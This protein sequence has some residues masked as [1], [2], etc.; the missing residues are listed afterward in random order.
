MRHALSK[1]YSRG[2]LPFKA[3]STN[4]L[5]VRINVTDDGTPEEL[6]PLELLGEERNMPHEP[7]DNN[8]DKMTPEP[9]LQSISIDVST[10]QNNSETEDDKSPPV[11]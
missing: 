1:V 9:S 7:R 11:N 6:R 2:A 10:A 4:N 3:N 5:H 8:E